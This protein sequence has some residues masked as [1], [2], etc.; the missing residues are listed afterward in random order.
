MTPS[1]DPSDSGPRGTHEDRA[2]WSYDEAF[3]R[4]RGLISV[5]EQERL[6]GSR[7]AIAG[8]GGVGGVHLATL[9]RLGVGAFHL[10]DPDHF[11]VSNFNRQYGATTRSLG[12]G[13]AEVM[14]AEAR[15]INPDLEL[16]IFPEA[17]T[18]ANVG[19]F[20]DGAQVLIDGIDFFAIETRRLVFR[21]ARRRGAWAITAGPLG[22]STAWLAFS[23][24][25]MSFDEYFDLDDSMERLDQLI[26]FMA[27]LSPRATHLSYLD[28]A[29]VDPQVHTGPSAGLACHLCSGVAAVEVLKILLGRGPVRAAPWYFQFD[30]Y[31]Q[32]LRKGWLRWGN[33]HPLQRLKRWLLRKRVTQLGWAGRLAA[34]RPG[35]GEG[36]VPAGPKPF[37]LESA[38]S[39]GERGASAPR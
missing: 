34:G 24:T 4:H 7:V 35:P 14:A 5:A 21:E 25:G 16:R 9:A 33:R 27:G 8:L 17:I 31:R 37:V 23:P 12:R 13:K 1:K 19:E 28:L 29:Q 10:A 18:P 3:C 38:S 36:L 11:D 15:A 26:A 32:L 39:P 20:L 22:F 2:R 30:A 6:R